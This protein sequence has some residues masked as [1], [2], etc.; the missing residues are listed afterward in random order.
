MK[1]LPFKPTALR[2]AAPKPS[3]PEEAKESDDDGLALFRRRKEMAPIMAADLERRLKKR[4]AAEE[5]EERRRLQTTGEKRTRDDS[6]DAKDSEILSQGE[7][8]NAQEGPSSVQ[9]S[10]ETP[11]AEPAST[12]DG[13]DQTSELVTPPPSKRSRL[14][15]NS[16]Q[17]PMLSAQLDD[18]DDDEHDPFPDASPT[19][20]ARPQPSSPSPIRSRKPE[21]TSAQN[22]V[23]QSITIDSDSDDE[24]RPT[25][26]A[27]RRSSINEVT[28]RTSAKFLE[29]TTPPPVAEEEDEFA[30]YIRKAQEN[31]ARQQAL[32]SPNTNESPKKEAISVMITSSIPNSGTLVAKFLFDKQLRVARNAWVAHQ[33]KKGLQLNTDDIILTWRRTKI[34][35]TSTL[36]GLG[37]RPCGNGRVEADGLGS[38]GFSNN[39]S[40]VHIEAWT[41]ELFQEMEQKE[42]LQRRR[43]AGELSDEEEPQQEERERFIIT[44][45]ARDIQPLECKVM[46]ETT[47]DTLIA[48]FR[49]QRQIGPDKEVSLWWDGDRLEEHIEME[50]AEIEEHDTIEVH[51][52]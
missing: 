32:Q 50:Q 47:V 29:E 22:Q 1:K 16:T 39:R 2:K 6:E 19:P 3:E 33:R 35:N 23:V 13:A 17:K 31:R 28:D 36:N 8:S 5:E 46:P 15:S 26:P 24:V 27:K 51:V 18:D 41:P 42:E 44:L 12:Q 43:D 21:L 37:I 52:Q 14:D 9:L 38:A 34:Y 4:R 45:K 25:Q 11:V 10:N 49:K 48:V 30:E 20:R 7:P 40:V